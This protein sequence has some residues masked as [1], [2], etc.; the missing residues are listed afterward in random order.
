MV[1]NDVLVKMLRCFSFH[2]YHCACLHPSNRIQT[3]G[4]H[5]ASQKHPAKGSFKANFIGVLKM[6]FQKALP[7]R[8]L[9]TG[10][11][12]TC[13]WPMWTGWTMITSNCYPFSNQDKVGVATRVVCIYIYIYSNLYIYIYIC[14]SN[15]RLPQQSSGCKMKLWSVMSWLFSLFQFHVMGLKLLWQSGPGKLELAVA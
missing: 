10:W 13:L 5:G 15:C 12:F 7:Q 8:Y 1:F 9:R 2:H 6:L 14:K 3:R 4:R 11:E